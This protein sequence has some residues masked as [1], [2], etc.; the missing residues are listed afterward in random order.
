MAPQNPNIPGLNTIACKAHK[1]LNSAEHVKWQHGTKFV[2]QTQG[3][4]PK[5]DRE[6]SK[7]TT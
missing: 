6:I 3:A 1:L 2:V 5:D 4:T 7:L